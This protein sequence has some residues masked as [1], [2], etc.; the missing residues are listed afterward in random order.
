MSLSNNPGWKDF[1]IPVP[2]HHAGQ[3]E[4]LLQ[5]TTEEL[6]PLLGQTML[7]EGNDTIELGTLHFFNGVLL[8]STLNLANFGGMPMTKNMQI[9]KKRIEIV[10][11]HVKTVETC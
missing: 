4:R 3:E 11:N 8:R 9:R 5:P 10:G 2:A 1:A 7:S 6:D